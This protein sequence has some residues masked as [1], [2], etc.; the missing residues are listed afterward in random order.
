MLCRP[1][2]RDLYHH[3]ELD[4]NHQGEH[5]DRG[6]MTN[7][8]AKNKAKQ[9]EQM[10]QEEGKDG[11]NMR[12]WGLQR[13][14]VHFPKSR[15]WPVLG[16]AVVGGDSGSGRKSNQECLAPR[17]ITVLDKSNPLKLS[18]QGPVQCAATKPD[19]GN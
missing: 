8:E 14:V 3:S 12:G 16:L 18:T 13:G 15:C 4:K 2:L 9:C 17:S 6:Y 5:G 10:F 1:L 19:A 7:R 11:A